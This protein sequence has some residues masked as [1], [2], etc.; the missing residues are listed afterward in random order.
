MQNEKPQVF[1]F[2]IAEPKPILYKNS[3][4]SH[5]IRLCRNH[6]RNPIA[7]QQGIRGECY[8][9]SPYLFRITMIQSVKVLKFALVG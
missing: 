7:K 4:K 2:C 8:I 1:S 5:S 9:L 6:N 3:A